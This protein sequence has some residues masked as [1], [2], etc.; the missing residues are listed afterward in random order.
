MKSQKLRN[1]K[2]FRRVYDHGKRFHAPYFSIFF[3]SNEEAV[4]R[5]G[6]TVTR[7]IGSA[8]VRNRCKRRLREIIKQYFPAVTGD[9]EWETIGLDMVINVRS[10]FIDSSF[11]EL[12]KS[13]S[14][15]VDRYYH[16]VIDEQQK[17]AVNEECE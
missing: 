7:K 12:K 13:F 1:S 11:D 9:Y 2:Q 10:S 16:S 14:K 6:I 5:I 4:Q 8:V 3:L 15:V 17:K